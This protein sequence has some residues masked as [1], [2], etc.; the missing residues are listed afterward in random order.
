MFGVKLALA[1]GNCHIEL[2]DETD[3]EVRI[4]ES[5]H[6][7]LSEQLSRAIHRLR[8]MRAE[9]DIVLIYLPNVWEPGFKR[10]GEDDFDL[11]DYLKAAT[12]TLGIPIQIINETGA[13]DYSCRASVMWHVGLALYAKAGGVPLETRGSRP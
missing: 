2:P 5:P 10:V 3:R 11:H 12:A 1:R 13:M 4:S 9:F 8:S 6:T 7:V